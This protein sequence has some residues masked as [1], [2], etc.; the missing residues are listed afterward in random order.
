ML[1]HPV[2]CDC[3]LVSTFVFL[4]LWAVLNSVAVGVLGRRSQTCLFSVARVE[5]SSGIAGS[6]GDS[7]CSFLGRHQLSP[8]QPL[9]S[10]S[11][12][13]CMM[14]V[15]VSPLPHQHWLQ[16]G[17]L[18]GAPPWLVWGG[19]RRGAGGGRC[20]PAALRALAGTM[21]LCVRTLVVLSPRAFDTGA[22]KSAPFP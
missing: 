19:P 21:C 13:Q 22:P 15:S 8:K 18:I 4:Q 6:S 5:T 12:P 20:R 2:A 14:R 17:L 16:S 9:Y 10:V 3:L 11:L 7:V 1:S